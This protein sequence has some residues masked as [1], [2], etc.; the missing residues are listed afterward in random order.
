M[1]P[2]FWVNNKLVAIP[3]EGIE[4]MQVL[5]LG[6]PTPQPQLPSASE[7]SSSE[8]S[9]PNRQR[10]R[11]RAP[12]PQ[13]PP[14]LPPVPAAPVSVSPA[15]LHP[16]PS[17]S[18]PVSDRSRAPSPSSQR[19]AQL[20]QTHLSPPP[21][22]DLPPVLSRPP[23]ELEQKPLLLPV[24]T[25][26]HSGT[27]DVSPI[28]SLVFTDLS[29]KV[30]QGAFGSVYECFHLATNQWV[31]VKFIPFVAPGPHR[32]G[33][34]MAQNEIKLHKEAACAWNGDRHRFVVPVIDSFF[35]R[36]FGG[37]PF[38]FFTADNEVAYSP[39]PALIMPLMWASL[40]SFV[41]QYRDSGGVPRD[42]ALPLCCRRDR[43]E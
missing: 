11:S 10:I 31:V 16:L 17:S 33:K 5:A 21:P 14:P 23:S 32:D 18:Q 8:T 12:S 6:P 38:L 15:D 13:G 43:R 25:K 28:L 30:G 35:V 29:V 1:H 7:S 36:E 37:E 20:Q 42:I 39:P 2:Q 22:Q 27:I 41:E 24:E 4:D 9:P 40:S 3:E 34:A 19:L 26:Y